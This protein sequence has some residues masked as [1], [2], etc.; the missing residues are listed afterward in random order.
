MTGDGWFCTGDAVR[1]DEDG[2]MVHVGRQS[3][4]ILKVGGYKISAR[5]IEEVI[6][7][8][9]PEVRECAVFGVP[10]AE[11][12]EIIAAGIVL[13]EDVVAR[14]DAQVIQERIEGELADYKRPRQ[15]FFVSE[16]PRNALGKVQK[17]K[18]RQELFRSS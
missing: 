13:E 8:H 1:L 6:E 12:G 11:W 17:H 10:D 14:I 16:I 3:V 2:Y 5:E 4:D 18:L 15:I 7:R 9:V